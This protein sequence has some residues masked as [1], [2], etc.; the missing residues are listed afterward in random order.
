MDCTAEDQPKS[1]FVCNVILLPD[2]PG[3]DTTADGHCET[4]HVLFGLTRSVLSLTRK[5]VSRRRNERFLPPNIDQFGPRHSIMVW[6]AM[7]E[8][9]KSQTSDSTA[10]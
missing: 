7:S 8:S 3:Q 1:K 9:G 6:A 10:R 5:R 4:G 2:L